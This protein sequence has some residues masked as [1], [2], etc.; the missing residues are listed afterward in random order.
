M[1]G[2]NQKNTESSFSDEIDI[3][4]LLGTLFSH[5]W[6]IIGVTLFFALVGI[7]YSLSSESV[8]RA[9][10]L[11]QVE[12]KVGSS[13]LKDF[14]DILPSN[15]S[16]SG[17]EIELI[18][19]RM[20]LG[21][22]VSDLGLDIQIA[23]SYMPII[24]KRWNKLFGG[25]TDDAD[26]VISQLSLP[27]SLLGEKLELVF[28]D[29][30]HFIL[31]HKGTELLHGNTGKLITGN[32]ISIY[33]EGSLDSINSEFTLVKYSSLYTI[34][35]LLKRLSVVDKGKDT[36][37]LTL[38][39]TGSDI[40]KIKETLN[41]IAQNYVTQNVDRKSEEAAKSLDFLKEQLPIIKNNLSVAEEKLNGYRKKND[42][43]DLSLEAKSVLDM[44][45]S[46]ETQINELSFKEAEI[47]KLYTKSHSAYRAL[48]EKKRTLIADR[49]K[50]NKRVSGMPETQQEVLRLTRDVQSGQEVYML[51][52]NKQQE[53]QISK[54]SMVGNVRIIDSAE[55]DF[56]PIAPK[57]VFIVLCAI[58]FGLIISSGVVILKSALRKN[59]ESP[60]QLEEKGI[61]VYASIPLSVWQSKKDKEHKNKPADLVVRNMLAV[62]SPMDLA[63]ESIRSL[64]TSLYFSMLESESN[65][66]LISGA[67]SSIGKTFV[68]TNLAAIIAQSDKKVLYIDADMRRGYAH[69]LMNTDAENGLSEILSGKIRV[70]DAIKPTSIEHLHFIS[71]GEM[72]DYPSELLL[73]KTLSEMIDFAKENYDLVI[74]DT[75]PILAV[76]DAA[77]IG[78]Y[79]GYSLLVARF[80]VSTVKEIEISIKRF[81]QSGININGVVLN[82]IQ[83]RAANKYDYA[84]GYYTYE[85][86]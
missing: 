76:T 24:G 75:P 50:L 57:K 62:A 14:S 56:K 20:I 25:K 77:I 59:I 36:G 10:A 11:I 71:R 83:K 21:K 81:N 40:K 8:Y 39:L 38:S 53:L 47:S 7:I 65:V 33:I 41:S 52:L 12:Q 44:L 73:K 80:D 31:S 3:W 78:K 9:D 4:R 66:L 28:P 55:V 46:I 34:N 74:I 68:S 54:A 85:S 82:A 2:E 22:T 27:E 49:D 32:S 1:F 15:A 67:S 6:L 13:I 35:E 37:M 45:T 29:K 69:Q 43:V 72:P 79:A 30:A 63:L 60:E 26:I 23:P 42:S 61:N 70:Q 17:A 19:S 5:I 16:G 58:L 48:M 51:L 86:K 84:A 64:R 18:K